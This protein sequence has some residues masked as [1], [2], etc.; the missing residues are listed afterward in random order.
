MGRQVP[1]KVCRSVDDASA[2][3][4]TLSNPN[5]LAIVCYL[6]EAPRTVTELEEDLGIPQP[7]LSQQLSLLRDAGVIVSRRTARVVTYRIGDA[8]VL[9]VV[10]SLRLIFSG[11]SELRLEDKADGPNDIS[12][13]MFD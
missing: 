8:R 1:R 13:D 9:P 4:K 3:I 12:P 6:M 5:R 2:F 7:T 10:Q 11:L